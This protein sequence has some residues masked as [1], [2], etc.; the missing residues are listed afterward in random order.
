MAGIPDAVKVMDC[1][2]KACV[3]ILSD[4]ESVVKLDGG[5]LWFMYMYRW[6][7]YVFIYCMYVCMYCTRVFV[8]ASQPNA[9]SLNTLNRHSPAVL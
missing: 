1:N 7:E 8:S 5:S 3:M 9:V 4:E 2:F 6:A